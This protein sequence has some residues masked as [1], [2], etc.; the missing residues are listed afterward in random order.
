VLLLFIYAFRKIT[1]FVRF[2]C[3]SCAALFLNVFIGFTSRGIK[4]PLRLRDEGEL[5]GATLLASIQPVNKMPLRNSLTGINR[6]DY[7]HFDLSSVESPLKT[8]MKHIL[9]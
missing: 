5:R 2:V 4:K 1:A 3:C 6:P 8:E 7:C 9:N